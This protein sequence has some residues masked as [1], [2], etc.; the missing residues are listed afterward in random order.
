MNSIYN[1]FGFLFAKASSQLQEQLST[2]SK[3]NDLTFKQLGMLLIIFDHDG[4]TQKKAG[5]IQQT[6]RTTVTQIV[7]YLEHKGYVIRKKDINDRRA[8]SLSLSDSGISLAAKIQIEILRIQS[9][10]LKPLTEE[11][12]HTLKKL[13]IRLTTGGTHNE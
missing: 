10:Y 13:M 1:S 8:Y 11:E 4:I 3:Q 7:D 6:D 12:V 5:E 2:F 9:A